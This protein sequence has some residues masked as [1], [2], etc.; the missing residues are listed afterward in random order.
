[1]HFNM[2]GEAALKKRR[3]AKFLLNNPIC[4]FCGGNEQAATVDHIPSIQMFSLRMRPKGLECP[5]CE[6]CNRGSRQHE[7]VAALLGR[8]YPNPNTSLENEEI[9]RIMRGVSNNNP[10]LLEELWRWHRPIFSESNIVSGRQKMG[11][12]LNASGPLLNR[13]IEIFGAKLGLALH[14]QA[15]GKIV[16]TKGGV[17]VRWFSNVDLI[18]GVLPYKLLEVMGAPLTLS[19]GDW[20]VGQQFS[21]NFV[22]TDVGTEGAYYAAFRQAF[23]VLAWV[24]VDKASL[25]SETDGNIFEPGFLSRMG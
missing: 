4:C 8:L 1:M 12:M 25:G 18:E 22:V 20:H 2:T 15:T 7:Q 5:A 9:G 24:A 3:K 13:S 16:P 21:Y 17:R 19:Q 23:A 14:Y 10:G 11:A 6:A